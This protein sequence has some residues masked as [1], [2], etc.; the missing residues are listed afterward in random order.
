MICLF[1]LPANKLQL[2][3]SIGFTEESTGSSW[4]FAFNFTGIPFIPFICA[5]CRVIKVPNPKSK[6]LTTLNLRGIFCSLCGHV[7]H[8]FGLAALSRPWAKMEPSP[9]PSNNVVVSEVA[10]SFIDNFTHWGWNAFAVLIVL[11]CGMWSE[12]IVLIVKSYNA[13]KRRTANI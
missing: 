1:T 8:L 10:H 5:H 4:S 9:R 12:H 11:S 2:H 3:H 6:C 13:D 7:E